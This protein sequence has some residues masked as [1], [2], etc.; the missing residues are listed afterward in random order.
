MREYGLS[1]HCLMAVG[2]ALGIVLIVGAV[3]GETEGRAVGDLVGEGVMT[4]PHPLKN[5]HSFPQVSYIISPSSAPLAVFSC[6]HAK[7]PHPFST[8]S[9]HRP[10][11]GKMPS[12]SSNR[13]RAADVS[14]HVLITA[15]LWLSSTIPFS[16][17][18]RR[19]L[20]K[21]SKSNSC[22]E[23]WPMQTIKLAQIG[24]TSWT[25]MLTWFGSRRFDSRTEMREGH[26]ALLN[27][28]FASLIAHKREQRL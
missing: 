11:V 4:R 2:D 15:G 18:R 20:F 9:E 25:F 7:M 22:A 13:I 16:F 8:I 28:P 17:G 10:M 14:L 26:R 19:P 6:G 21:S 12:P 3:L 24:S 1:S 27:H 5:R 23:P